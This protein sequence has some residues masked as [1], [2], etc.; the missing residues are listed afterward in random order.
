MLLRVVLGLLLLAGLCFFV[1]VQ[2]LVDAFMAVRIEYI[3]MLIAISV[4]MIWISCLKWRLF[5]RANGRDASM[6]ELMRL[7]TIGY[8]FS[9]FTPSIVGGDVARSYALGRQMG[10]QRDAFVATFLERFTGF[11]AMCLLAVIFIV[12]GSNAAAGAELA[13]LII[14]AL[15]LVL[16][17]WCFSGT[18]GAW[19]G[20]VAHWMIQ[21]CLPKKFAARAK[22]LLTKIETAMEVMRDNPSLFFQAMV[23]SFAF[24]ICTVLNT[25]TAGLAVGWY[26]RDFSGLFVVVPLVLLVGAIPV[27]FGG[28]GIQEGAFVFFLRRLGATDGMSLGLGL[29]LRAKVFLIALV[30]GLLFSIGNKKRAS[31]K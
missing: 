31:S 24:H 12:R 8:F 14:A 30:G 13:V 5:L 4:L 3:L 23:L 18:T 9:T 10:S 20:R 19:L 7:Y 2:P 27:S 21:R 15:N 17:L 25:Y 26:Q 22:D 28:L 11:F 16:A 29:L 1:G 6:W